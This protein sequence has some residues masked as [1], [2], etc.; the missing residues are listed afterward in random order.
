[1]NEI[2][3]CQSKRDQFGDLYL[4]K[5]IKIIESQK[6][7]SWKGP[8][9]RG[10][11]FASALKEQKKAQ[12]KYCTSLIS[13]DMIKLVLK[14]CRG[15]EMVCLASPLLTLEIQL[16]SQTCANHEDLRILTGIFH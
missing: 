1:M 14:W 11:V 12:H 7:P 15:L 5:P 13:L 9:K 2:Q 10:Y 3:A 6:N 16:G 8:G 4:K